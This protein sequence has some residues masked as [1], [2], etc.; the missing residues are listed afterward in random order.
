MSALRKEMFHYIENLSEHKLKLLK[1]VVEFMYDENDII[2]EKITDEN[3]ME[4]ER[5]FFAQI[6]KGYGIGDLLAHEDI[7]W[8]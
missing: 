7:D 8:D 4:E 3:M 5:V 6:E 2:Y 1:P